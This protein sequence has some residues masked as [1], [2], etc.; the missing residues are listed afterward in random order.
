[1]T[2]VSKVEIC[3]STVVGL[4]QRSVDRQGAPVSLLVPQ[5][6]ATVDLRS[7]GGHCVHSSCHGQSVA[8]IAQTENFLGASAGVPVLH[9]AAFDL[10]S[11]E[12][13]RVCSPYPGQIAISL[14]CKIVSESM[15]RSLGDPSLYLREYLRGSATRL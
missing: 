4:G 9:C 7:S 12:G 6:C 8:S 13:L 15:C 14:A 1:M 5:M 11:L 3:V 10:R 2:A